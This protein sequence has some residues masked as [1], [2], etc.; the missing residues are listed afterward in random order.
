MPVAN[1]FH[2]VAPDDWPAAGDYRPASLGREG[3]VHFSFAE[4]VAGTANARYQSAQTLMVVE[5]DPARLPCEIRVEDSYGTGTAFP[6]AYG[7]IPVAAAVAIHPLVR[8]TDGAWRFTHDDS[9]GAASP[10]R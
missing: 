1:L 3:F 5:V 8:G 6:H 9:G 2:I 7:P 10:G 4:Q